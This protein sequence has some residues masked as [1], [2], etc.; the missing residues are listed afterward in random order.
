MILIPFHR[1]CSKNSL[2]S[3][4]VYF[5]TNLIL[6][7]NHLKK[8]FMVNKMRKICNFYELILFKEKKTS[9]HSVH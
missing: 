2:N 6:G 5:D 3:K 1:N 7:L 8:V 4:Y 9:P